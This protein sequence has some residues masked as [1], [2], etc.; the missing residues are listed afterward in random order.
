MDSHSRQITT[1]SANVVVYDTTKAIG[2]YTYI[3]ERSLSQLHGGVFRLF[4]MFSR[5]GDIALSKTVLFVTIY[6]GADFSQMA[7]V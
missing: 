3:M 4:F 6:E 1:I 2:L 7:K 5:T